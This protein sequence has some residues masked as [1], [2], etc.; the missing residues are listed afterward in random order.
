MSFRYKD[1]KANG[2]ITVMDLDANEFIRRFLQHI[3][4][5]NFYKIRY[6]GILAPVNAQAK[7]AQCI[8][9]I[10]ATIHMPFLEGLSAIDVV[11]SIVMPDILSCPKCKKGRLIYKN[12]GVD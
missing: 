11:E 3:L 12:R 8:A 7:K 9:L 1:N 4:P 10:G 6:I 5:E 2:K